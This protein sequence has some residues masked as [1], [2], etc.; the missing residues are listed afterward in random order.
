MKIWNVTD[1]GA[2]FSDKLQTEKFQKAIDDCFLAGGGRVV[3]PCGVY[4]IG[5]IRLRSHV[6]L[7]LESGA[8]VMGSRDPED[9][10]H[11]KDD[12]I[13]PVEIEEVDLTDPKKGRSS[14]STTRWS[15][16]LIRAFD[17][18]DIAVIGEKGSYFNGQLCMD[19]E[20]ENNYRG[21]HGMSFWRCKNIRLEG[22]T[23]INS[24][25]WCHAIFQS[26]NI[27]MRNVSI[28][29]G[30]DGF[31]VRTCDNILVEDCNFYTG[32]DAIAGF[33]NNDVIIRNCR[34]NTACMPLRF[35]GN[36][37]LVENCVS[38]ERRFGSRL[39]LT[40][41]DKILGRL[42]NDTVRH[43]SWAPFSY[44][45]DRRADPRKPVEIVIRNVRFA[46]AR[47][48]IRIEFDGLHRWCCNMPMRYIRFENCQIEDLQT[49]GMIWSTEDEKITVEY[50]GCKIAGRPGTKEPIC[51]AGNFKKI[52]FEDCTF[53]GFEDPTIL[54][55]TDD[56][57]EFVRTEPI[58]VR[59]TTQEECIAAHPTGLAS[60]DLGKNLRFK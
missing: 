32:D 37:V 5:D 38:D 51:V 6:E 27:T 56:P 39:R 20:G 11:W 22:Y 8:I 9:Y 10:H 42:T 60:Q 55:G 52:L 25:N 1:Y 28:Y 3:I 50:V 12:T 36:N 21:P 43:E 19:P 17:A 24:S 16:G 53:E 2:C 29:S 14:L 57:V 18:E 4:V 34:L 30:F 59:R 35:G 26:Q 44:Y 48:L 23:F 33:D 47:E 54:I 15:N 13:E 58:T 46:Q 31:D 45:C 40:D 49:A 7:Y 41:E